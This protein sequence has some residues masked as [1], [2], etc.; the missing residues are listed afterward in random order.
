[1]V[2]N[3]GGNPDVVMNGDE[4]H[5]VWRDSQNG[6]VKYRRGQ[7]SSASLQ[8]ISSQEMEIYKTM[9]L[10]GRETAFK[11]GEPLIIMYN[12]GSVQRMFTIE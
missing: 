5:V 7:L 2:A 9:D 1:M 8:T 3:N 4:I 10:L 6:T 11:T 12:D